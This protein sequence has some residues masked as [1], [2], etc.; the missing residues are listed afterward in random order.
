MWRLALIVGLCVLTG[1]CLPK[2]E[3]K[4]WPLCS[5]EVPEYLY[6]RCRLLL[7]KK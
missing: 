4:L 7:E 2:A 5:P 1:S 3:P 6:P